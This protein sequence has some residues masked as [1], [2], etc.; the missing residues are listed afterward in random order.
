MNVSTLYLYL[1]LENIV[2]KWPIVAALT[3]MG[4]WQLKISKETAHMNAKRDSY[5][6]AADQCSHYLTH[7]IPII[8]AFHVAIERKHV[9][10]LKTAKLTIN[11]SD[12]VFSVKPSP[13]EMRKVQR[14]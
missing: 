14:A 1:E 9:T 4:L 10:F 12:I 2:A 13:D 3:L 8:N 6:L 7:I 11:G 5:R